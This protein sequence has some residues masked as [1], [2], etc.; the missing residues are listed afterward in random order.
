[1]LPDSGVILKQALFVMLKPL[2]EVLALDRDYRYFAIH[3]NW[4]DVTL[5]IFNITAWGR[6]IVT[7]PQALGTESEKDAGCGKALTS[8]ETPLTR[9]TKPKI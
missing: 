3:Q 5:V 7:P 2:I 9:L 4:S 8:I 1:M 6:R